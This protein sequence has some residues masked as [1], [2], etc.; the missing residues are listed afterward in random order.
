MKTELI[1]KFTFEASHALDWVNFEIPHPHIWR[2][3]F[4]IAGNPL[5]GRLVDLAHLRVRVQSL[6]ECLGSTFLNTNLRVDDSV[7][8]TPT[9]ETLSVFFKNEL[10]LI[11]DAEFLSLNPSIR[12]ESV[13]VAICEMNGTEQ[14]AIKLSFLQ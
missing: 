11:L 8:L 3:E 13:L 6:L 5:N 7:R 12:L 10:Q 4:S 2:L 1:L 9:C 14:G